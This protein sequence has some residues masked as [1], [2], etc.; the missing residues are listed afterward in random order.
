MPRERKKRDPLAALKKKHPGPWR[1]TACIGGWAVFDKNDNDILF[2]RSLALARA[3]A[4]LG[5]K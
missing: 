2:C 3:I 1:V 4:K 5:G